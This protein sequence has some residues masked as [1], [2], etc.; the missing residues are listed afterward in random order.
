M[1]VLIVTYQNAPETPYTMIETYLHSP[2]A[3]PYVTG[4]V[5]CTFELANPCS[6]PYKSYTVDTQLHLTHTSQRRAN[7]PRHAQ[8]QKE[9]TTGKM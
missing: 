6:N 3:P 9:Q 7:P 1:D 8:R 2:N 4:I 5:R